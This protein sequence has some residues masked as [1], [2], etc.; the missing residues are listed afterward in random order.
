[1]RILPEITV[2][3]DLPDS[4]P[5]RVTAKTPDARSSVQWQLAVAEGTKTDDAGAIFSACYQLLEDVILAFDGVPVDAGDPRESLS[6]LGIDRLATQ[7]GAYRITGKR[8]STSTPE[9]A[10]K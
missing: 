8:L 7:L 6:A 1:M 2:T 9:R 10:P 3:L 5:L 4:E